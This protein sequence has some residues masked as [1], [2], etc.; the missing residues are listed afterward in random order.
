MKQ[1]TNESDAIKQQQLK[2]RQEEEQL[3]QR[4]H[5]L[6]KQQEMHEIA[7]HHDVILRNEILMSVHGSKYENDFIYENDDIAHLNIERTQL[8]DESLQSINKKIK[9][10]EK[11]QMIL[12]V[13]YHKAL[14]KLKEKHGKEE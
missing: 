10:N 9:V 2:L 7:C 6:Q 11:Q 1:N 13:E 3:Y 4:K 8:I 12:Q 5:Q 14:L